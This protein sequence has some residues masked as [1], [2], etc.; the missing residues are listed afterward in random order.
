M[1]RNGF[2]IVIWTEFIASPSSSLR[3]LWITKRNELEKDYDKELKCHSQLLMNQMKISIKTRSSQIILRF[4][5]RSR[6]SMSWWTQQTGIWSNIEHKKKLNV[7]WKHHKNI[8]RQT[9]MQE[10]SHKTSKD[11]ILS[12]I[13]S[14]YHWSIR[15]TPA[16]VSCVCHVSSRKLFPSIIWRRFMIRTI[17]FF[18]G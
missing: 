16:V 8:S 1:L 18:V 17:H 14:N 2:S 9:K 4:Y 5:C 3:L 11:L 15:K 13:R 7:S 6:L 12:H 10:H